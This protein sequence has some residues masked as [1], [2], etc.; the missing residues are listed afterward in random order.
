MG[1]SYGLWCLYGY[2]SSRTEMLVIWNPSIRKSV[3][4]VVPCV[5]NNTSQEITHF[6]FGVCPSTYDPT[7]VVM[8]GCSK[9]RFKH[10]IMWQVGIFTLSSKTWKMIPTSNLPRES[11]R[12]RS[13]TQV[14]TDRG[15]PPG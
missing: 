10:N 4:I 8:S 11:I 9:R 1:S 15:K 14:A 12:V 2:N 7:I 3:R 5:L 6:G 13:Y